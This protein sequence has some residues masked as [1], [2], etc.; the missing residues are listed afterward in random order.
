MTAEVVVVGN[1]NVDLVMGPQAPWPT[2]GTEVLLPMSDL[3]V[4]GAAGNSA[5]ALM[6]LEAP[7]RIIANTSAD[8]LGRWLREPFGRHADDWPASDRPCALSVGLTHPDGERTFFTTLGHLLDFDQ[9]AVLHQIPQAAAPGAIALLTGCFV[10]PALWPDC[11]ALVCSLRDRG[12]SVAL[13]TG[14]PNEGWSPALRDVLWRWLP[15]CRDLLLNDAEAAGLSGESDLAAA[16]EAIRAR[17]APDARLVVKRGAEGAE[18]WSRD[19]HVRVAA[20][21]VAV[22][23]TIGAGDTFNAGYLAALADGRSFPAAVAA[24]V[25]AASYAVSTRP[26]RYRAADEPAPR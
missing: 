13:D 24:G 12:Y 8:A 6:A 2:P 11:G 21:P 9:A 4:G 20:P 19:V 22:V 23:D 17:L 25:A 18:A 14:W 15:L 1:V 16:A 5:L 26:R 3:R 7:F 10:L